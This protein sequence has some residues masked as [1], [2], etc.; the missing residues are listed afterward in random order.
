M[1][2][3]AA[4]RPAG[5]LNFESKPLAEEL[6]AEKAK[7]KEEASEKAKLSAFRRFWLIMPWI[8][9]GA[10]AALNYESLALA[11][12]LLSVAGMMFAI[13]SKKQKHS[14]K[15]PEVLSLFLTGAAVA[16]ETF[17]PHWLSSIALALSVAGIALFLCIGMIKWED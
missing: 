7:N 15:M 11:A 10:M 17:N 13:L 9:M 8:A 14:S 2:P 5:K 4:S 12:F 16:V 1:P 3:F 6:P